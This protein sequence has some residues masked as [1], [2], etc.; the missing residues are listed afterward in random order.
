MSGVGEKGWGEV[1]SGKLKVGESKLCK[2][3]RGAFRAGGDNVNAVVAVVCEGMAKDKDA[4]PL[5]VLTRGG[6]QG[7][8]RRG[9]VGRG[10]GGG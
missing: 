6:G 1:R 3:K 8:R 9:R 7:R 4:V 2:C 5:R 10:W